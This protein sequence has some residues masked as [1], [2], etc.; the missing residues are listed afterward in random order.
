MA[1]WTTEALADS[2]TLLVVLDPTS[3]NLTDL[4]G[5]GHTGTANGSPTYRVATGLAALPW[6]ITFPDGAYF[7]FAD[8]ADTDLGDTF[9]IEAIIARHD[10]SLGRPILG[11][12][13]LSAAAGYMVETRASD[14]SAYLE[15]GS[16]SGHCHGAAFNDTNWHQVAF[17]RAAA[18]AIAYLDGSASTTNLSHVTFTDNANA[19]I[20][21]SYTAAF[22]TSFNGTIAALALYKSA[23]SAGRIAAHDTGLA[24]APATG[25][26]QLM[27]WGLY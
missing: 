20:L 15:I 4:S 5:G 12:G 24:T 14:D 1:D 26:Q 7:S 19:L 22:G 13:D 16:S 17:T 6:G 9:T 11:K 18:D 10:A 21:G 2:P 27:G 3:G 25:A 8:H 23:L